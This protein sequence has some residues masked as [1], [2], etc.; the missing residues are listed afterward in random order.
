MALDGAV[1]RSL[2]D[3]LATRR[4]AEDVSVDVIQGGAPPA[5]YV[6]QHH[7]LARLKFD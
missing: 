4:I 1:C 6:E 5:R 2:P 7:T 3:D